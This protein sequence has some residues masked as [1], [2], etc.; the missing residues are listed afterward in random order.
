MQPLV[1]TKS[2]LR[3]LVSLLLLHHLM[4]PMRSMVR[5]LFFSA[6]VLVP[7]CTLNN[8]LELSSVFLTRAIEALSL[9]VLFLAPR[10]YISMANPLHLSGKKSKIFLIF[11]F[12]LKIYNPQFWTYF[13]KKKTFH[14][15]L[16]VFK[17]QVLDIFFKKKIIHLLNVFKIQMF[18][19][20]SKKPLT[21]S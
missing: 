11:N 8:K 21:F 3:R 1:A 19:I 7:H 6:G 12:N 20:F 4:P 16:N 14:L 18:D 15:L 17:I 5:E 13:P 9:A 10:C 2:F